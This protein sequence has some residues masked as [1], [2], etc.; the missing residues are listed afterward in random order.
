MIAF[1]IGTFLGC[2]VGIII[3]Y[4][5]G[6]AKDDCEYMKLYE[7]SLLENQDLKYKLKMKTIESDTLFNLVKDIK[8]D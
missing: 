6:M 1:I 3:F 7:E 5:L 8:N 4:L 2:C